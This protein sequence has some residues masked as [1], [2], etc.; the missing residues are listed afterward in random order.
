MYYASG[1]V[2]AYVMKIIRRASLLALRRSMEKLDLDLL[3]KAYDKELRKV[4]PRR[5]NP[6][7]EINLENLKATSQEERHDV[8]GA[9]NKRVRAKKD[10]PR[11][12][13]VLRRSG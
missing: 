4:F 7:R 13:E 2:I 5:K 3:A 12:L 6:F 8:P 1:G 10:E 11:A 9:T